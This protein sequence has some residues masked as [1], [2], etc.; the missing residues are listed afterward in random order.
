MNH[1]PFCGSDSLEPTYSI[2]ANRHYVA[3]NDCDADGPIARSEEEAI[4]KWDKAPRH[5]CS[6]TLSGDIQ[7]IGESLMRVLGGNK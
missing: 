7:R 5:E 1:C 4:E 3:C 6:I 2:A